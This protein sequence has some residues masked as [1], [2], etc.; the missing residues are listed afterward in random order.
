MIAFELLINGE[1]WYVSQDVTAV[2]MAVDWVQRRRAERVSIHVGC[3][4]GIDASP[5][6]QVHW[7][8]A[9]LGIGDE[10]TIRIVDAL[11][12]VASDHG[13]CSYCG[14]G[15]DAVV[16][17]VVGRRVAI[18]GSCVAQFDAVLVSGA[19]LPVGA[20]LHDDPSRGCGFCGKFFGDVAGLI[21]RN[22]VA[23]C[24]ECMRT[25]A[26]IIGVRPGGA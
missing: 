15:V 5:E 24:P 25:C 21:V 8:D 19:A 12:M 7:L 6:R 14:A 13:E 26:D 10:V 2:T 9:H 23:I 17:V 20:S 3:P 18:C 1:R 11:E 4:E 16:S 22:G